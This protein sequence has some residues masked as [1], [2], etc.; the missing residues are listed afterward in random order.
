[1]NLNFTLFAPLGE[2]GVVTSAT[3]SSLRSC[4]RHIFIIIPSSLSLTNIGNVIIKY[5][6]DINHV[7]S[8]LYHTILLFNSNTRFPF[9]RFRSADIQDGLFFVLTMQEF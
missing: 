8:I 1:M 5:N 2:D 9:L 4:I 7:H 3:P 6:P